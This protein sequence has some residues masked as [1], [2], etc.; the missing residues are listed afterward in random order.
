VKDNAW[1]AGRAEDEG[2]SE[3]GSRQG[4]EPEA[5]GRVWQSVAARHGLR[6]CSGSQWLL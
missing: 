3:S 6:H 4:P 2:V 1:P 5:A